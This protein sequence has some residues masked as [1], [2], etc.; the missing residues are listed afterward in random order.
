MRVAKYFSKHLKEES[1]SVTTR[2][3]P[4][5][6]IQNKSNLNCNQE[7]FSPALPHFPSSSTPTSS[8]FYLP[9]Y[10]RV[11]GW[12]ASCPTHGLNPR[13]SD[14]MEWEGS[15]VAIFKDVVLYSIGG[16]EGGGKRE[17]ATTGLKVNDEEREKDRG[18]DVLIGKYTC[19]SSDSRG[20]LR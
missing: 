6:N 17:A 15:G 20:C 2:N 19:C 11:S 5:K 1:I 3:Q 12:A 9:F 18:E 8:F 4:I 14:V 7:S 16:S 13:W 10:V